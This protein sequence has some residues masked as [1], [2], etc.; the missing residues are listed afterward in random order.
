MTPSS[1]LMRLVLLLLGV[2]LTLTPAGACGR[3]LVPQSCRTPRCTRTEARARRWR[4]MHGLSD[5]PVV[6]CDAQLPTTLASRSSTQSTTMA[7]AAP[8]AVIRSRGTRKYVAARRRSLSRVRAAR[9]CHPAARGVLDASCLTR[10]CCL[11]GEI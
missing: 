9:F 2:L 1:A 7:L 11:S 6:L 3:P 10:A 5:V 4:A 8:T